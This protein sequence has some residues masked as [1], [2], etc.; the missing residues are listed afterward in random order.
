MHARVSL[1]F[2]RRDAVLLPVAALLDNHDHPTVLIVENDPPTIR[3]QAVKTGINDGE[4]VEILAGVSP[5]DRVVTMGNRLVKAGQ[6]VNPVVAAW[7]D[8]ISA[9]L[10]TVQTKSQSAAEAA[11]T[12]E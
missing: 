3:E 1:V 9:D 2:E 5:T 10:Q 4:F 6:V 8:P 7:P 12:G 11:T